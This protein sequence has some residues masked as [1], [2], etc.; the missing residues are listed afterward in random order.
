KLFRDQ[1]V[2]F[3]LQEIR[4]V[5]NGQLEIVSVSDGIFGTGLNAEAAK[6]AAAIVDVINLRVSFVDADTRFRGA[7]I[8]VGFD[9]NA[10]RG[11]RSRAQKT[12]N[13]FL[14]AQLVH[15]Q[16]VL[17]AITRLHGN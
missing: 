11:A 17:P 13:A 16:Q 10:F 12:R 14:A 8:V 4:A 9:V 7:R 1:Q 15:M 3:G 5:V 2:V 6:N